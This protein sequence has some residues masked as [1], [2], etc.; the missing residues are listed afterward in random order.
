[1]DSV[2]D[3]RSRKKLKTPRIGKRPKAERSLEESCG[4]FVVDYADGREKRREEETVAVL[5]WTSWPLCPASEDFCG[6]GT[7]ICN[8]WPCALEPTPSF[9][10]IH[11]INWWAKCLFSFSQDC[12]LVFGS[13]ALEALLIGVHCKKRYIIVQIQYNTIQYN[14]VQYWSLVL[15]IMISIY[16]TPM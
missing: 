16:I 8:R 12:S 7:S 1:M 14:T 13:F 3:D 5:T 2:R 10:A 15:I 9:Y 11:F 4:S 6:S